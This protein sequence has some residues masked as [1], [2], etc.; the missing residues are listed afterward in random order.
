M[1]RFLATAILVLALAGAAD[2]ASRYLI[3]SIKQI[4]P[5][6]RRALVGARG[7]VG[8]Q[9]P[10]GPQGAPAPATHYQDVFSGV[11][12]LCAAGGGS[13]ASGRIQAD[14][15]AGATVI[16]GGFIGRP[17]ASSDPMNVAV[18]SDGLIG[19]GWEVNIT[20]EGSVP[21]NFL[22]TLVCAS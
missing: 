6:V 9:G 18:V 13:C 2:A 21:Y 5:S 15:P 14:C 4:K 1:K 12:T 8:K 7:P 22:V 10:A 16:S 20:N 19:N 11:T 17:N 3:T